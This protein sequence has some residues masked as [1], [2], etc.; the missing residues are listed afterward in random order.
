MTKACR[1][2]YAKPGCAAR[3]EGAQAGLGEFVDA[4]RTALTGNRRK[5]IEVLRKGRRL[6]QKA[7]EPAAVQYFQEI[8]NILAL[9]PMSFPI[10]ST[11]SALRNCWR[12]WAAWVAEG[13]ENDECRCRSG[14]RRHCDRRSLSCV[15]HRTRGDRSRDQARLFQL[16]RQFP[17]DREPEKFQE[18]RAA[19]GCSAIR[20]S[21]RRSTSSCCNHRRLCL[22]AAPS[23][24]LAVHPL[25]LIALMTDAVAPPM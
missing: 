7:N 15:G 21:V 19:Y 5:A 2:R 25:D 14:S 9:P 4:K 18:I 22:S 11:T 6:A 24:D 3:A 20:R 16:V 13:D 8:E 23:Y 10:F 12:S 1:K 17:P